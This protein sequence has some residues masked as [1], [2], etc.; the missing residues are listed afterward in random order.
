MKITKTLLLLPL[1]ATG[2]ATMVSGSTQNINV[3]AIDKESNQPIDGAVCTVKDKNGNTYAV[4]SNPGKIVVSKGKGVLTTHCVKKGYKQEEVGVGQN[5]DAWSVA[6]VV[7]WP[8][9]I[10][11]AATGA[12]QKYPDHITVLMSKKA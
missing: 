5:F 1:L 9:L 10:V 8:G 11:D 6:N 3:Q 4:P 7:F 2:C 12:I